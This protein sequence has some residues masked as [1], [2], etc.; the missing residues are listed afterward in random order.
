LIQASS[1]AITSQCMITLRPGSVFCFRTISF[2]ANERGILHRIADPPEK[3]PSSEIS[4]KVGTRQ[5]MAQPHA[6]DEDYLLQVES[7]EFTCPKNPII[8]FT[9][10]GVDTGY[11]KEGSK[12][13]WNGAPPS[14]LSGT[15]ALKEGRKGI[16]HRSNSFLPRHPLH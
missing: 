9:D 3:R 5:Q 14:R 4:E 2:V 1:M 15:F 11:K 13:S 6:P 12:R 10:K 16:R 7:R 8:H